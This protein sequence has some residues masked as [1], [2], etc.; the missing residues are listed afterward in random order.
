[1]LLDQVD[2]VGL[3]AQDGGAGSIANLSSRGLPRLR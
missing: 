1:V 3:D 2:Q